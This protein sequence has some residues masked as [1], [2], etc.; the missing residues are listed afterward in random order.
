MAPP[1]RFSWVRFGACTFLAALLLAGGLALVALGGLMSLPFPSEEDLR[2]C[3][4]N[5]KDCPV[6]EDPEAEEAARRTSMGG[7]AL[8]VLGGATFVVGVWPKRRVH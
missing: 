5:W 1:S 2:G 7:W 6:T 8:V 4:T 3:H